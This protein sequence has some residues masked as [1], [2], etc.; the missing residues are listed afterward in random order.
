MKVIFKERYRFGL[1]LVSLVFFIYFFTLF[2]MQIG[3]HLFYDREA[4]VLLSRVEKINASRGEILDSS[5]NVIANN[6]TA[7]VLKIS[8]EQ[9]YDMSLEDRDEMLDFLSN[10]LSIDR[11][12]ILSKIEAP[13]G[14]LKDIEIVELS[15][16]MLYRISEKGVI[17]LHF[18]GH[19]LLKEIIWWMILILILL[20]MLVGLIKES[21]VLFI[22]LKGMIIILR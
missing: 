13:R 22:M 3:K 20:G 18:Y 1:L 15:P 5:L 8:L 16:E 19:I 6:L 17:I 11:E 4:T 21:F 14:Y 10:T 9:Y 12:L 7:F 2:K